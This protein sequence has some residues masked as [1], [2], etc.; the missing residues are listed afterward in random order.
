MAV[1]F[2]AIMVSLAMATN[3]SPTITVELQVPR[4]RVFAGDEVEVR[5]R[6]SVRGGF[7]LISIAMPPATYGGVARYREGF[8]VVSGKAAQVFFKGF[9]NV[10]REFRFR[11]RAM[12]R[13]VY[14]FGRVR[15][16]YHHLFGLRIIEDEVD[17]EIRLIVMP[18]YRI[19]RRSV[20]RIKP[21]T[22]TPRVTPNSLGHT[23]RISGI[24]GSTCLVT[25]LS[26]LIGRPRQGPWRVRSWLMSTIGRA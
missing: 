9:G 13:G 3:T 24:L 14:D 15:Y 17:E 1:V 11:V 19:I 6:V 20:G 10:E 7:G 25:R 12:K 5:A 8:E 21:A 16:A 4:T 23:Q 18:R 2:S 26:S 22:V